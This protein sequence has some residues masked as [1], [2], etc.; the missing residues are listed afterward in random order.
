MAQSVPF[1]YRIGDYEQWEGDWELIDGIPVAMSPAPTI[2]HQLLATRILT[3]L[4]NSLEECEPCLV[5]AEAE[6]RIGDDTVLRPDGAVICYPPGKYL[7]RPPALVLEVLS[8]STLRIDREYKHE[9]YAR[10]GVPH[11]LIADPEEKR[12]EAFRLAGESYETVAET[13]SDTLA[14]DLGPC[15]ARIDVARVMARL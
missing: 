5:V 12:V 3:E 6:W 8:P 13:G 10:E 9:R 15:T 7:D 4:T 11:Y 2:A 1:H 14:F